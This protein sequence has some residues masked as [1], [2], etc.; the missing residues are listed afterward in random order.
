MH[1]PDLLVVAT[2]PI[3]AVTTTSMEAE[4][5]EDLEDS[6]T[7]TVYYESMCPTSI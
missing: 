2:I 1:L 6:V 7:I 4:V 5:L 3:L